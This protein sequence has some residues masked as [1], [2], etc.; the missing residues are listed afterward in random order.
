MGSGNVIGLHERVA[1]VRTRCGVSRE[2]AAEALG[3][4]LVAY[5]EIEDGSQGLKGD[6]LVILAD[7]CGVRVAAFS[8]LAGDAGRVRETAGA[9]GVECGPAV[10]SRFLD[11]YFELD[12][13]LTRQG[14]PAVLQEGRQR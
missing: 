8:G 2:A 3:L 5:S 11:A 9:G 4:S 10:M 1:A 12:R 7:L 14:F 6:E 13:F